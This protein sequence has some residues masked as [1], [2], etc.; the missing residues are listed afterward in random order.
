MRRYISSAEE[1]F[2]CFLSSHGTN[3]FLSTKFRESVD[4]GTK[5]SKNGSENNI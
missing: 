4:G 5:K 1:I 2:V 3:Y